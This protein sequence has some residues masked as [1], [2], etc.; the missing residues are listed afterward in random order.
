M[1][2]SP[3]P[4]LLIILVGVLVGGYFLFKNFVT[5]RHQKIKK[6][7]VK[8]Y[9]IVFK[10]FVCLGC[11]VDFLIVGFLTDW[12][13]DETEAIGI[14]ALLFIPGIITQCLYFLPYMIA[15]SKGH[16]QETAIFVLNLFAGWTIV[17][18]I[19]AL[20][21]AFTNKENVVFEPKSSSVDE[22]RKL[23]ELLDMGA[24]TPEEFEVKKHELLKM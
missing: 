8:K 22:I 23:K 13:F 1:F 15:N 5:K 17:A 9:N 7:E 6:G 18:W 4:F 24:I 2:F 12:S 11:I 10:I 19:I 21:W 3:L 20:I 16:T 14:I